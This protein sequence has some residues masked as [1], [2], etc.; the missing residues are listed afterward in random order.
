MKTLQRLAAV[1]LALAMLSLT[2]VSRPDRDLSFAERVEAQ[3][4]IERVYYSHQLGA[5]QPFE[6]ATPAALLEKKVRDYLKSMSH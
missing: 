4:A 3:R 6:E 5:T 1:C 2:P